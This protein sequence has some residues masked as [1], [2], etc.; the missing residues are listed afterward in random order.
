MF[1]A[2]RQ[3]T[4]GVLLVGGLIGWAAGAHA[5]DTA[6][7]PP[8]V[9]H[10]GKTMVRSSG[11]ELKVTVDYRFAEGTVGERWMIL[12]TAVSGTHRT[13]TKIPKSALH[14]RTPSGEDVTLPAYPDFA[15]AYPDLESSIARAARISGPIAHRA[16]YQEEC[17][18]DYFPPPDSGIARDSFSVNDHRLCVGF[19]YFPIP[20]G[21][22]AG[23]Y[24]LSVEL[25]N[26]T[27]TVPFTIA[28]TGS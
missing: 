28:G 26:E 24:E 8:R 13:S 5:G 21:F 3:A 6:A 7:A 10:L 2:R 27:V 25:P 4:V 19:L 22:E 23:R 14:L 12:K 17:G 16:T 15:K 11:A 18:L 20:G 9:K 1:E